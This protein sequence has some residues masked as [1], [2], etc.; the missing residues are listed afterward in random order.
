MNY[1]RIIQ[2]LVRDPKMEE[3][4]GLIIEVAGIITRKNIDKL[5]SGKSVPDGI[6][7][8]LER[9]RQLMQKN[10]LPVI[11]DDRDFYGKIIQPTYLDLIRMG[12]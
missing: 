7:K 11:K 8:S 6:R 4:R 1:Q 10:A 2:T 3:A 5:L 9:I 12:G